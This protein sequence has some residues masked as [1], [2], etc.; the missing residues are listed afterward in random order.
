MNFYIPIAYTLKTRLVNYRGLLGYLG[1]EVL[2]LFLAAELSSTWDPIAIVLLYILWLDIY[3]IGY[4][5]NDLKDQNTEGE[6]NRTSARGSWLVAAIARL[7][8]ATVILIPIAYHI[9]WH[10]ASSSLLLNGVLLALLLFHSSNFVRRWFP[11]RLLTFSALTFYKYAPVLIPALPVETA[12]G[13]LVAIFLFY[14][15]SRIL[16]YT[17]RKFGPPN[18]SELHRAQFKIQLGLLVI[19]SPLIL[20]RPHRNHYGIVRWE[21]EALWSYFFAIVAFLFCAAFLRR[22]YASLRR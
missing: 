21:F 5:F 18:I 15:L 1:F 4:I 11:G 17:L 9:G 2:P 10:S 12:I 3:E 6:L 13:A 22:Q 7:L 16:Y 20:L 19:A 14:G 8:F